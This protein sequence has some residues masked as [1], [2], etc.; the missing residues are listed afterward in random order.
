MEPIDR[1]Q[2]E[3]LQLTEENKI[4]HDL[5]DILLPLGIS[6]FNIVRNIGRINIFPLVKFY[7]KVGKCTYQVTQIANSAFE[8]KIKL[9]I[10]DLI[11]YVYISVDNHVE[12]IALYDYFKRYK[13]YFDNEKHTD[14]I[15]TFIR[16]SINLT[17][18]KD[19][20]TKMD[21][22]FDTDVSSQCCTSD[23]IVSTDKAQKNISQISCMPNNETFSIK[24]N[25]YVVGENNLEKIYLD[26]ILIDFD[27][28]TIT[29]LTK[30]LNGKYSKVE[31][32]KNSAFVD[33]I[34]IL[35]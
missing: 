16:Q 4:Y 9:H 26:Q 10:L 21:L 27:N 17:F 25:N 13:K 15:T 24:V 29:L 35:Y 22:S 28:H 23:K 1:Q 12:F 18:G 2:T 31:I 20:D 30:T 5:I 8:G 3:I 6:K 32:A 33:A 19:I 7:V 11:E 14:D 34:Q